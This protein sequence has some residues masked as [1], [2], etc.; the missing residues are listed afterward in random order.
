MSG[1]FYTNRVLEEQLFGDKRDD[2]KFLKYMNPEHPEILKNLPPA[3][4]LTSCGDIYNNFSIRFNKALKEAGRVSK[5]LYFGDEELQ[6][7]FTITNPDHPRSVEATDRMLEWFEE[8]ALLR[9]ERRSQKSEVEKRKKKVEER[10]KDGS[11][12]NQKV[13]RNLKERIEA[14]PETLK[15]TAIIDCTREYT[16]EQ[17]LDAWES[18]ARAFTGIGIGYQNSSRVALCGTITAEPIFAMYGLNM[19]GAEVSLFSYPDF[20][21]HGMWRDMI[22]KEKITDLVISDIMVTPEVWKEI[23]EVKEKCGLRNVILMHSLMGGPAVGPAELVFNEANYHL[24]K[25]KPGAVFMDDLVEKYRGTEVCYDESGGERIAFITHSSGTTKGTRKLL[26]YTDKAFNACLDVVPGGLRSFVRGADDGK[27]LRIIQLFD[28][29]SIMAMASQLNGAFIQGEIIVLTFFGFMHPKFIRAIDYYNVSFLLITGFMVDKW[30]ERTDID[31]VDFSSLKVAGL[32]GGYTSPE[33]LEKFKA[34]FKAH[35]F[36]HKLVSGYGMSEA[37]GR[38]LVVEADSKKDIIGKFD[39]PDEIRIKDE[40]DGLFYRPDEGKRTGLLYRIS[41]A[42]CDNKLDGEILFE[43]TTI[44]GR[45]FVCTNDLV[46]VNEDGSLSFA[47]RA[48][49]Y[50]VNNEGLKFDSG[51]VDNEMSAHRAIDRC[52]VVPVMEKRIHDTVPVLY[53]IPAEKGNGAAE[54][55]RQAFVDVYVK[56]RKIGADNLPTQF[57]IVDDIPLNANGKLDIYRIT[58]ERL[59]GDAYNII[60]VMNE[61]TMTDIKTEHVKKLN[62]TTAGTLPQGMENNSAYNVFDYFTSP[63]QKSDSDFRFTD[64][65][66]PWKLFLPEKERK[67]KGFAMPEIT[68]EMSK[69][70]LKYGNRLA[71]IPV[72]RKSIDID[73]E[74]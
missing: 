5:L 16:Y 54:R 27:Q 57:M 47:G 50:F 52:A 22:E 66:R 33:K 21:P 29:S 44:E 53:V 24:L 4:L 32:V 56:E 46:R 60:P 48:D 70:L 59:K 13:W 20:L 10:I 35:G 69:F 2:K 14:D 30:L 39:N 64:L 41:D 42:R 9:K 31:D 25:C 36:K 15:K 23:L 12:T 1:M 62:S 6:H 3:F 37:G 51:I 8:Q 17:M 61:G 40:N 43:Y 11:I 7:I 55:I 28:F 38:P 63:P 19:T 45:D 67:D 74:E 68:D 58:R 71:G 18:Y 34:F 65:F 72:G 26:P 49:K 73:F